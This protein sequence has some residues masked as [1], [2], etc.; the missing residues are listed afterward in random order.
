MYQNSK[1]VNYFSKIFKCALITL[2]TLINLLVLMEKNTT[3]ETKI[4][5]WSLNFNH[6]SNDWTMA[7]L[8]PKLA[9]NRFIVYIVNSRISKIYHK[10]WL[11]IIIES[12]LLKFYF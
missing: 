8:E 2:S 3:F 5:H 6:W 12:K 1:K 4:S 9:S 7:S 11:K 10:N